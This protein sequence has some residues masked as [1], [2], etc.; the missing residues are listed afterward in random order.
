MIH[1]YCNGNHNSNGILC[2]ECEKL[3]EYAF[4]RLLFC[5]FKEDKPICSNCTVHCYK[6]E[7]REKVKDVMKYAGPKMIIKHP[8][9]AIM[10]LINEKKNTNSIKK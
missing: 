3:N 6:P 1:I 10:H 5:P 8:Y 9:L 7:M 4:R 2:N